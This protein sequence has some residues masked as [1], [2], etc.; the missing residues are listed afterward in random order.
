MTNTGLTCRLRDNGW[1]ISDPEVHQVLERVDRVAWC[2]RA[3][4]ATFAF[5]ALAVVPFAS[6]RGREC[7]LRRSWECQLGLRRPV[8]ALA[9]KGDG[10]HCTSEIC[11]FLLKLPVR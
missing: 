7:K 1:A 11:D 10:P 3:L 2:C 4:S 9:M 5:L 6:G 8:L